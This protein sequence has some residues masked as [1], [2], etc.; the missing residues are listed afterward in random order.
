MFL[1]R[2]Q[3]SILPRLAAE[4]LAARIETDYVRQIIRRF[5]L[6][7]PSSADEHWPWPLR[8]I[9]LGRFEV[10]REGQPLEFSRKVPKKTLALLK[11]LIAFGGR[12]V[13]EQLLLDTF[14]SDE[15]GDAATRSLTATLH[16]LRALVGDDVVMQQGGKLSLDS[17]RVWVD[18]WTFES[19]TTG[20]TGSAS[21]E[22]LL[23][24]YRG[25]FLADDEGEP[26]S[27]TLRERLRGKFIHLISD[28]A[29]RL[30]NTGS[31]EQA[32]EC[33]LRGLDADPAIERF[34]QG[35]MRCYAQL[36]R[37]SEAIAAYQRLKRMLAVL[38]A[39]KPSAATEKLYQS[40]R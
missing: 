21:I 23:S 31:C 28:V 27:V 12:N 5:D 4:A 3:P 38:L 25:A 26:W 33:Y 22:S 20:P 10:L 8:I 39:I 34:Y 7:A 16:R 18:V 17:Q 9:T 11:A 40:L 32:I 36:D 24:L 29:G 37:K 1:L 30:E 15:E 6:P 14:W 13:R 19:L 35:L 2:M